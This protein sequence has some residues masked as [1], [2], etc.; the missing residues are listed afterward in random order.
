MRRGPSGGPRTLCPVTL[1]VAV[2]HPSR[3]P[4]TVDLSTGTQL[5]VGRSGAGADVEIYDPLI[6]KRHGR[7]WSDP[8]GFI[9]YED[10]GSTNGSWVRGTRLREPVRLSAGVEV[11]LGTE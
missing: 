4:S 9:W 10:L 8:E 11:T 2:L 7:L 1:Q 3:G 5:V 6:S